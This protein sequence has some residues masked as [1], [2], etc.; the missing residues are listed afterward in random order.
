M[1]WLVPLTAAATA[2]VIWIAAP[3]SHPP[4]PAPIA[5]SNPATV[6][7]DATAPQRAPFA[8]SRRDVA[9]QPQVRAF[10]DLDARSAT[11]SAAAATAKAATPSIAA[12]APAAAEEMKDSRARGKIDALTSSTPAASAA[13]PAAA[14]APPFATPSAPPPPAQQVQQAPRPSPSQTAQQPTFTVAGR[15]EAME[16]A[17]AAGMARAANEIAAPDE[18]VRW[19][20]VPSATQTLVERSTD[21]GVTWTAQ[22]VQA[23]PVVLTAGAAPQR[24]VCWLVGQGGA[25]F[26]TVDGR[27]WR[28]VAFPER[29]DLTG[30][31]ATDARTATVTA[32]DGRRFRTTDA[33]VA[34]TIG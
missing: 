32:V 13:A 22:Q 24:D 9:D 26:V 20:L 4:V 6:P 16:I 27:T 31:I 11:G 18:S 21:R 33:G 12:R 14:P 10:S 1:A 7:R 25:V 34:W 19:R 23:A 17:A 30:V 3:P 5:G 28:R 8:G 2:L 15:S 29:I